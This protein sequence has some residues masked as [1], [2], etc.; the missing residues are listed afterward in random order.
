MNPDLKSIV[1][2]QELLV[3]KLNEELKREK[4]KLRRLKAALELD[5]VRLG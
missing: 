1:D 5:A 3:R 2:A 4:K